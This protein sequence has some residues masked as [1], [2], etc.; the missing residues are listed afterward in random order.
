MTMSNIH[1]TPEVM[2]SFLYLYYKNEK[3][4]LWCFGMY[5]HSDTAIYK[6]INQTE[7]F[8]QQM[9]PSLLI[10]FIK[11]CFIELS[12]VESDKSLLSIYYLHSSIQNYLF[13]STSDHIKER[14][15]HIKTV[16]RKVKTGIMVTVLKY[17]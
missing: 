17:T 11:W 5:I 12:C 7:W 9:Q 1:S 4:C 13:F 3:T 6:N 14:L 10:L 15:F 2:R 8:F 16:Y